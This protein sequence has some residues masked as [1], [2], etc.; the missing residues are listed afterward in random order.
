MLDVALKEWGVICQAALSGDQAILLRKGGVHEEDGPGRF[1]L[2]HERFALFPAW[3][4]QRADWVKPGWAER[5]D[6][7]DAEPAALTMDGYA[8]VA[9]V[10]PVPSRKAFD[11]LD[12]LHVWCAPYVD[13]RFG[14]KP[15][16][17]LY[18]VLLRAYRL[19]EPKTI[20]MND[21]YWGCKSWVDLDHGDG[22][23]TEGSQAVLPDDGVAALRGRID[24]AF[25]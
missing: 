12:D 15:D 23:A 16:R 18:L 1:R 7:A 10:W 21:L 8:E 20:A 3:E 17:P 9:G 5:C 2:A 14:Y 11:T 25:R 4:H 6:E 22:V 13:M 19:A 24:A